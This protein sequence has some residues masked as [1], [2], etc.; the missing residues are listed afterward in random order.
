MFSVEM[1]PAN[2]GDCLWI[3]YGAGNACHRI[4][5][6]GGP[7]YAYDELKA[8]ISALPLDQ[9]RFDL[10]IITHIDSDHIGGILEMLDDR[11]LGATFDDIWFN[12]WRHLPDEAGHAPAEALV[13]GVDVLGPV[14]GE[15]LSELLIA[16]DL[17]WNEA[18]DRKAVRIPE[19]G[20]LPSREFA[21]GFK[22]TLLSPSIGE[23]QKLRRVWK[24]AIKDANLV[25]ESTEEV[26]GALRESDEDPEDV[27]GDDGGP[28]DPDDVEELASSRYS[29]DS[30]AA[31]G[32]TI[33]VL[34]EYE[35]HSCL[36]GGDAFPATLRSS[37]QQLA[38]GRGSQRLHVDAFKLPH[39]GGKR[40]TNTQLLR[41][42]DCSRFLISTNGKMFRHPDRETVARVVVH[43][44]T[45]AARAT[46]HFN[47]RSERNAPW[48]AQDVKDAYGYEAVYPATGA[49]GL[50]VP[51]G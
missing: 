51:L 11:E 12:G 47:Y 25:G 37:V 4:L 10:L 13:T 40:N 6:D 3:E 8:R 23:L 1:L 30:S 49:T 15:Q 34:A 35:G 43:G 2:H 22:L 39:H 9:R 44:H 18:F 29:K 46:L 17:P 14:Q 31:N 20:I 28:I 27:M 7:A 50:I 21:D 48:D 38:Q 42:L 45:A 33:A 19:T 24:K 41:D 32:S 26:L 5:I 36:L 16:R